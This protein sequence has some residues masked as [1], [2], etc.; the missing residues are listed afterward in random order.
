MPSASTSTFIRP[1]ASM[2]SLSHSME[3]A[4]RHGAVAHRHGLVEAPAGQHEAADMLGQVA[5]KPIS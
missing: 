1:I 2:S 5:G 4:V 3:G